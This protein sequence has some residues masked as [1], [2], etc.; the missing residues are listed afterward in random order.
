[1]YDFGGM[2]FILCVVSAIIGWASIEF[3]LWLLS[4]VSISFGG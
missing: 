2:V 3:I 4:F 1:M